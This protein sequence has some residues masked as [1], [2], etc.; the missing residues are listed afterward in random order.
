MFDKKYFIKHLKLKLLISNSQYY[1]SF[2][3]FTKFY[4]V[5][6]AVHQTI[7]MNQETPTIESNRETEIHTAKHPKNESDI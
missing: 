5:L 6:I 4:H 1:Q 7:I 2:L 3:T